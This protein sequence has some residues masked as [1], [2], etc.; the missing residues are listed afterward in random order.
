MRSARRAAAVALFALVALA[1]VPSVTVAGSVTSE[2]ITRLNRQLLYMAVP[3]AILVEVILAYTVW[4]FHDSEEPLPTRE[5]RQLEITWTVATALVLLF[6]GTA[7]F[8]VLAHPMVT[9]TPGDTHGDYEPGE[10]PEDAVEAHV[11]AEQFSYTF[12]YPDENVTTDEALVLPANRTVYLYVTSEDVIHSVHV[13]EL[14]L[15]QDAFPGEYQLIRTELT[16]TGD[17]RLYCAELCG[18]GHAE[19]L[20][21]VRIVDQDD[22]ESWLAEKRT[23]ADG[24][25]RDASSVRDEA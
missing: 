9:T 21:T 4:R 1:T 25:T 17:Y 6:V 5:N 20:S 22:Y 23:A 11:V 14:G 12:E 16:G 19:M 10:A 7:S 3:I 18:V 24:P 8:H 2:L 15:K 13:P